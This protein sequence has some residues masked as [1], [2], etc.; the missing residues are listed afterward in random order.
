MGMLTKDQFLNFHGLSL[1]SDIFVE[2]GTFEGKTLDQAVQLDFE[3]IH[4]IDVIK[5][6]SQDCASRYHSDPRVHCHTGSSP[7][8]L[9]S[10][11]KETKSY[12][13]WLD[14]HYQAYR[15]EETCPK[16]GQ[17]PL[18][19][20][21]KIIFS[22]PW[23]ISPIILIDDAFM[24]EEPLPGFKK[25]DW[26]KLFQIQQLIPKNYRLD[27]FESVLVVNNY[28]GS[29]LGCSKMYPS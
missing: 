27:K 13:F 18:L 1:L 26:P 6:Y 4:T 3:E 14:A 10:L 28:S 2:T 11:L 17:C 5:E 25:D 22:V 12:T 16:Y 23:L 24:F 9:P 20:E 8:I 15:T 19:Q 7:D 21:L 29:Y